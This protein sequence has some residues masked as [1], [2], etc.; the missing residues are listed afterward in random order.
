MI[1]LG[2]SVLILPDKLPGRSGTGKLLIPETSKEMLP[3]TGI[4][5]QV[6][7]A[8][9]RIN[10]GDSVIFPRKSSSVIVID[11]V[12]HYLNYEHKIFYNEPKEEKA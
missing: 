1:V 6:G 7:K 2:K 4:A 10:Q 11:N 8:C 12:D 3:E 9:E 5:V